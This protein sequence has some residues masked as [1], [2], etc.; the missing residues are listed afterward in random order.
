MDILFLSAL[1]LLILRAY[2]LASFGRRAFAY[3]CICFYA[4]ACLYALLLITLALLAH[5]VLARFRLPLMLLPVLV[6]SGVYWSWAHS[7]FVSSVQRM[8]DERHR[9]LN[10]KQFRVALKPSSQSVRIVR[11]SVSESVY[12][13]PCRP[14]PIC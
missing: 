7:H 8:V 10:S 9:N 11:S 5:A 4:F 3:Y 12:N 6:M 1:F 13:P 14:F 2:E